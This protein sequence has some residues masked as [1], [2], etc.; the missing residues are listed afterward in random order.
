MGK[1]AR[2]RSSPSSSPGSAAVTVIPVPSV[3]LLIVGRSR[4]ARP[5][6]C[7]SGAGL[8]VL[9]VAAG[10]ELLGELRAALLGDPAVDEDVH[11][12]RRDVAQDPRVVRDQQDTAVALGRVAVDALGD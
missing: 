6:R 10:L 11:E 3:V 8:D 12:V 5:P 7:A 1:S 4:L 2:T 9:V